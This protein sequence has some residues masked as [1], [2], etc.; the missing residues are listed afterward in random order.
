M[1]NHQNYITS[2]LVDEQADTDNLEQLAESLGAEITD[3]N[4]SNYTAEHSNPNLQYF[5]FENSTNNDNPDWWRPLVAYASLQVNDPTV[6]QWYQKTV[7]QSKDQD[8]FRITEDPTETDSL[9]GEKPPIQMYTGDREQITGT[10]SL[11]GEVEKNCIPVEKA[12]NILTEQAPERNY[13]HSKA[14]TYSTE[15]EGMDIEVEP[16]LSSGFF[17]IT[18][19]KGPY[20]ETS[21]VWMPYAD[22]EEAILI[23]MPSELNEFQTDVV[24]VNEN[25][26]TGNPITEAAAESL[27]AILPFEGII[28]TQ[29]TPEAIDYRN[30][31]QLENQPY[32]T[33]IQG[34]ALNQ[35][36]QLDP[37]TQ[38]K[39]R[40]K[41]DQIAIHPEQSPL[42]KRGETNIDQI[43]GEDHYISWTKDIEDQTINIQNIIDRHEAFP[44]GSNKK[45]K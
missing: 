23:S 13:D 9:T 2:P 8:E 11:E 26:Y 10:V 38:E 28:Q 14:P 40:K 29:T 24:P 32:Q 6:E 31:N 3:I 19:Q 30:Q 1:R 7:E 27:P 12:V 44:K 45:R 43:M 39:F 20:T 22:R 15:I 41:A 36:K 4:T 18:G 25:A 21:Q 35:L 33:I 17:Q 34:N 5:N 37:Q 16:D 42:D